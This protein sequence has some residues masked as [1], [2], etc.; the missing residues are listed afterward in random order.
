MK[1]KLGSIRIFWYKKVATD[2]DLIFT[3]TAKIEDI[4]NIPYIRKIIELNLN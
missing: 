1:Y 2:V 4:V 3:T